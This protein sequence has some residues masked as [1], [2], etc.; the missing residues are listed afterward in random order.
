MWC[1]FIILGIIAEVLKVNEILVIPSLVEYILFG[2]GGLLL[3][4]QIITWISVR[5]QIK[6]I[7]RKF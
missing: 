2:V 7:E 4:I 1:V 5:H 6:K 3:W